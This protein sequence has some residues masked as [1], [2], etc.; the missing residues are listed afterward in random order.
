MCNTE[1][2]EILKSE[3]KILTSGINVL[4]T[5]QY[6]HWEEK[7]KYW[8]ASKWEELLP[9]GDRERLVD[10]INKDIPRQLLQ[11]LSDEWPVEEGMVEA[12]VTD[13]K[14]MVDGLKEKYG[15]EG[16]SMYVRETITWLRAKAAQLVRVEFAL[17]PGNLDWLYENAKE[18][19]IM[20]FLTRTNYKD[21]IE[22]HEELRKKLWEMHYEAVEW[23]EAKI[24]SKVAR[25]MEN[26]ANDVIPKSQ[27]IQKE[28]YYCRE[29][30]A[31][32][33]RGDVFCSNP[34]CGKLIT[35]MD[36]EN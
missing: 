26:M 17:T 20:E 8:V 27:P 35:Y 31:I 28:N 3:V 6:N 10:G 1:N 13:I 7:T 21:V 36:Y 34:N 9:G 22:Y 30:G 16:A 14:A 25:A 15:E 12:L 32:F 24:L 2:Y 33:H 4:F 19:T 18:V 5:E 23:H 29:C 11:Q